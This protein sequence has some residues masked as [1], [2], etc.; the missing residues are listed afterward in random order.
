MTAAERAAPIAVPTSRWA[1]LGG[2]SLLAACTQLLWLSFAAVDT[3]GIGGAPNIGNDL[4]AV[5]LTAVPEPASLTLLGLGA[6]GM[7]GYTW[8]RRK[9]AA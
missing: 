6:M 8:R 7:A 1:I 3:S 2:Y 9:M 4:D 5:S